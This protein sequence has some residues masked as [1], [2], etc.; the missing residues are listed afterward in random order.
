MAEITVTSIDREALVWLVQELEEFE[1]DKAIRS[2]L[3]S[4]ALVFKTI[5]RRNL[6]RWMGSHGHPQ[7]VTG[8]LLE[9]FKNRVKRSRPGA[10]SGFALPEGSHVWLVDRGTTLRS[11]YRHNTGIMPSSHFWEDASREG[12]SKAIDKLREGVERKIQKIRERRK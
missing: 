6:R 2:G 12:E 4:A 11:T 5:G 1:K 7:G 9:S 3:S 10:L 8:N